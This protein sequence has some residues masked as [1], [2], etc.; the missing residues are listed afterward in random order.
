LQPVAKEAV[1]VL[2][3]VRV[4]ITY[5]V[6]FVVIDGEVAINLVVLVNAVVD[7]ILIGAEDRCIVF[8]AVFDDVFVY[9]FEILTNEEPNSSVGATDECHDW[10][11]V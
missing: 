9:T 5:D 6:V 8:V 11:F 4:S 1:A 7:A 2:T 3:A 10:R